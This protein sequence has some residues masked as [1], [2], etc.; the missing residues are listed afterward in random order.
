MDLREDYDL[1]DK[2]PLAMRQAGLMAILPIV[3]LG[4]WLVLPHTAITVAL[5]A[6]LVLAAVFLGVALVLRSREL[7]E[8]PGLHP[9]TPPSLDG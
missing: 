7:T 8:S 5:L 9:V 3:A 6:V 4:L 1:P 2:P